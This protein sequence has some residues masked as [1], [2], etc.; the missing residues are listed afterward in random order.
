MILHKA[1]KKSL[2]NVLYIIYVFITLEG[3]MKNCFMHVCKN[4][5]VKMQ[6]PSSLLNTILLNHGFIYSSL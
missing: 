6:I 4:Q 3:L 5:T 2:C 1:I